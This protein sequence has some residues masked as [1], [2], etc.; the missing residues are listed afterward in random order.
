MKGDGIGRVTAVD[1]LD[2]GARPAYPKA[3][4]VAVED[5]RGKTVIGTSGGGRT[6]DY[7]ALKTDS[8]MFACSLEEGRCSV[9]FVNGGRFSLSSESAPQRI[10]LNG[11][12]LEENSDWSSEREG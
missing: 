7:R 5:A 4:A 1:V 10:T 6:Y 9:C 12:D 3:K 11:N 8:E 2:E